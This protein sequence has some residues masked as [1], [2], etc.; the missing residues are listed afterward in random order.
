M[1]SGS[2]RDLN[3]DGKTTDYENK[4]YGEPWIRD[5]NFAPNAVV[6][7]FHLCYA[8]GNSEPGSADPSLSTARKRVDNY[9]A[10]FLQAGAR[11]VI[12]S[13]HSHDPYYIRGLFTTRQTIEE[14]WR[15]SPDANGH[16]TEYPSE[17]NPGFTFQMDPDRPGSYYRS[18]AGKMS[19]RTQDVTGAQYS[20]TSRDPERDGCP[21]EREPRG[22]TGRRCTDRWTR[23]PQAETPWPR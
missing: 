20:D 8:S 16:F 4:Y 14:Y 6:L 7:L 15:A 1:A 9:A 12:A 5:L 23:R 21:R 17:R 10:A 18:I 3:G 19:L 22:S 2:T 13:G 11:A